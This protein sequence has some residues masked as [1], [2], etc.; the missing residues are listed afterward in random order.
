MKRNDD[1][2]DDNDGIDRHI[3]DEWLMRSLLKQPL[4]SQKYHDA[5]LK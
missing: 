1:N 2:D 3:G 5:L 4:K